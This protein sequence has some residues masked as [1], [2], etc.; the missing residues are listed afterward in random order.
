MVFGIRVW[1]KGA[2]GTE[3]ISRAHEDGIKT[4]TTRASMPSPKG[5]LCATLCKQ[6]AYVYP[7]IY[8]NHQHRTESC[9][10][11]SRK[12]GIYKGKWSPNHQIKTALNFLKGNRMNISLIIITPVQPS[13]RQGEKRL[14]PAQDWWSTGLSSSRREEP[15]RRP[16]DK[17]HF[18]A[19]LPKLREPKPC[20]RPCCRHWG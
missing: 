15:P 14:P 7:C 16:D 9:I 3:G 6:P 10:P 20:T 4:T 8:R 2:W 13:I 17:I 19:I 12:I 5:L 1:V 18:R 11:K